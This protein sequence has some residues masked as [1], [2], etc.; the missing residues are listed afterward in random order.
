MNAFLLLAQAE[1][2]KMMGKIIG[3]W[4]YVW[5]SYI[6]TWAGIALYGASLFAR[7]RKPR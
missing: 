4:E 1:G 2:P 5:A 7:R 3:G 6:L